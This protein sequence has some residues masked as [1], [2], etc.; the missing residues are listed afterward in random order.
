MS[1]QCNYLTKRI[2]TQTGT[3][4][5]LSDD[6]VSEPTLFI[7]LEAR[8]SSGGCLKTVGR[9]HQTAAVEVAALQDFGVKRN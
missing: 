8:E 4:A 7:I 2:R 6:S 1:S 9:V 3:W 5:D